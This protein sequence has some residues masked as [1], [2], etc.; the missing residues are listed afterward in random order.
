MSNAVAEHARYVHSVIEGRTAL[1]HPERSAH[2][3]R[4][5]LRCVNDHGID[6][7][8]NPEPIVADHDDLAQ[9]QEK[10]GNLLS[11]AEVEMTNLYQQLAGSNYAVLLTDCDGVLLSFLSDPSF[12]HAASRTG[13]MRGA[14]WSEK[15][16]GT[17]GM[18]TCLLEQRPINIH[19]HEHF[20]ARNT[21]LTCSAAPI[22][23]HQGKPI[24]VLD[25]S[26]ESHRAQ[27]HTLALVNMSAHT[28]ENGVFLNAFSGYYIL[29]FHSRPEFVGTL[30]EGAVALTAEGDVVAANRG[31]LFHLDYASP[32]DL[33][34]RNIRSLFN[35]S[36]AA[37]L[38]QCSRHWF[39]PVPVFDARRGSRF[40]AVVQQPERSHAGATARAAG[41]ARERTPSAAA[42]ALDQIELGD[43]AM[44]RNVQWARRIVNREVPILICG[45]TGTGKE[46]F[47]KALHASSSR[48]H[49][50]FVA[51]NC[52]SIPETLIEAE[53]FGYRSG[54]FTGANREGRRGKIFQADG[55]TL[56]LDEIGDMPVHLQ[57]RLLRVLEEREVVPLGSEQS[58]KVN[59]RVVSAT[60]CNLQE[61]IARGEFRED[62]YFRLAG[63]TLDLPP[64]RER[65]DR[66]Q[67][68]ALILAEEN[69]DDAPVEIDD[70]VLE[71]FDRYNWPGNIRQ[72]RHTLRTMLALRE[73]STLTLDDVPDW[74]TQGLTLSSASRPAQAQSPA[75]LN[76]LENAERDALIRELDR[77]HWNISNVARRLEV[78]RNTLY[79]KMKRLGI[80]EPHPGPGMLAEGAQQ[81]GIAQAS[82]RDG[83]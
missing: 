68:V 62:L 78:S 9:R 51:I 13:L 14:I 55:G 5:W 22:F 10:L 80:R 59:V 77:F 23:D 52:A 47:A 66:R 56:F 26:G 3:M 57:A 43:P 71:A 24:A 36:L 58:I 40:F 29:R 75:A 67:L 69:R 4:S 81:D 70:A 38:A 39:N 50:P 79:R 64:L 27:Q 28:I 82:A 15:Y 8:A 32:A 37:L 34:N 73:G 60:H 33:Q 17:N 25:A 7:D 31:A 35:T 44:A 49:R 11:V 21:C 46:V 74:L 54:A 72:L 1:Q 53:L 16:Q 30:S 42:T 83:G 6:P 61:K 63:L 41:A 18:G 65:T 48:A 2:V 45:E 12:T 20:L 19:H 76:S